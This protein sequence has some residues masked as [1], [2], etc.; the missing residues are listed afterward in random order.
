[1]ENQQMLVRPIKES[2]TKANIFHWV[3]STNRITQFQV[4]ILSSLTIQNRNNEYWDVKVV[5]DEI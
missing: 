1:M 4:N 5:N 2:G 3:M